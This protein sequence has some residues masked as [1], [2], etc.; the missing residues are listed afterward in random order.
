MNVFARH[1]PIH[2]S[3]QQ[4]NKHVMF[5]FFFNSQEEDPTNWY[6][7]D[8]T[9]TL[10]QSLPLTALYALECAVTANLLHPSVLQKERL[11][12]HL[13]GASS[14]DISDYKV[15]MCCIIILIMLLL[16]LLNSLNRWSTHTGHI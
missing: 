13:L 10:A 1:D 6:Q 11:C 12:L 8:C 5:L 3:I 14:E 4:T 9:E 16:L 7:K 2:P 15:S